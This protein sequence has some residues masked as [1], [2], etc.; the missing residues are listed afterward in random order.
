MGKHP[1][2]GTTVSRVNHSTANSRIK[3]KVTIP[4]TCKTNWVND[5]SSPYDLNELQRFYMFEASELTP[6]EKEA[7]LTTISFLNGI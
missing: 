2:F 6:I 5:K 7:C 4:Q 1:L 3:R